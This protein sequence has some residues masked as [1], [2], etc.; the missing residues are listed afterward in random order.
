MTKHQIWD[1]CVKAAQISEYMYK[2]VSYN[3]VNYYK[4][5]MFL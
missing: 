5:V 3:C 2:E 4:A 1:S